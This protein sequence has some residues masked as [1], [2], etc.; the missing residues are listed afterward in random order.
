[1]RAV[2]LPELSAGSAAGNPTRLNHR[3]ENRRRRTPQPKAR[4]TSYFFSSAVH[5]LCLV[6]KLPVFRQAFFSLLQ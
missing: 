3:R 1:M 5:L 2:V 4:A 6:V